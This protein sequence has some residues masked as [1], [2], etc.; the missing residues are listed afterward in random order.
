MINIQPGR[1]SLLCAGLSGKYRLAMTL[2]EV[3]VVIAIIG[4]L[5]ALLLPA[6][7]RVR[8]SALRVQSKNNLKQI[9]LASHN[10]ADSNSGKL[11]FLTGG[12][13]L[14]FNLLP[15]IEHGNYYAEVKAGLRPHSSDFTVLQYISPADPT[16]VDATSAGKASYAAN[17]Q[18]FKEVAT[19][20]KSFRDG[21]SNTIAFAE[22]YAFNCGD[23]QFNWHDGRPPQVDR[24]FGFPLR[25]PTFADFD[26]AY[27]AY[28]PGLDDV[29]PVTT[30]DPPTSLGSLPNLTFQTRP[31]ISSCDPRIPQTPHNGGMLVALADGSVRVI[32]SDI[33][34]STF[35]AAVTRAGGEQLGDDW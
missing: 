28:N 14:F 5:I 13:S 1:L 17:A 6:V 26:R 15:Y 8:D 31:S 12:D 35:W 3:L 21:T 9:I 16:L 33:S 23:V 22:H 11:P 34:P 7:M 32:G 2:L 4:V 29:F 20:P 27:G 10:Y 24:S 18:A 30:G 25:R 19:F